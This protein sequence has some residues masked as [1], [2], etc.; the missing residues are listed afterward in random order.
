V[1]TETIVD[2]E[3]IT[4]ERIHSAKSAVADAFGVPLNFITYSVEGGA[5][6]IRISWTLTTSSR[7]AETAT[8]GSKP[9][10]QNHSS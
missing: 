6:E 3:K 1:S 7:A 9:I 5:D 4:W 10:D 8:I 2:L